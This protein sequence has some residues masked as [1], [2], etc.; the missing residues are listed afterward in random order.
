M[1]NFHHF[2]FFLCRKYERDAL[3]LNECTLH[4]W[5]LR[6][7]PPLHITNSSSSPYFSIS[8][9]CF[10]PTGHFQWKKKKIKRKRTKKKKRSVR[11]LCNFHYFSYFLLLFFFFFSI[12]NIPLY[13]K[14][15]DGSI[16]E[17]SCSRH[18]SFLF[19]A[20]SPCFPLSRYLYAK[21]TSENEVEHRPLSFLFLSLFLSLF[22]PFPPLS[23][24]Q[25]E[26]ISL[27]IYL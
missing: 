21:P 24:F 5:C 12:L 10:Q 7:S 8:Y 27:F 17:K 26:I 20:F 14:S 18:S 25:H 2:I 11:W 19:F 16:V 1:I 6:V 4:S 22:L 23:R 15:L 3:S 9:S 13:Q